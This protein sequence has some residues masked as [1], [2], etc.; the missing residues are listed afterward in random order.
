M[1]FSEFL[2]ASAFSWKVAIFVIV[3]DQ[4]FICVAAYINKPP[5]V[6]GF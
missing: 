5:T 6:A 2:G 1:Y 3:P 4:L